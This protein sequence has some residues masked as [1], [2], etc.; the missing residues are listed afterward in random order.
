MPSMPTTLPPSTTPPASSCRI[1]NVR[2]LW[3]LVLARAFLDRLCSGGPASPGRGSTRWPD[4]QR[5]LGPLAYL[6]NLEISAVGLVVALG[7]VGVWALALAVWRFG[8]IEQRWTPTTC[9][10]SAQIHLIRR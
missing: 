7:F 2:S 4:Q 5:V 1:T 3:V 9:R 10:R 8:R 6:A